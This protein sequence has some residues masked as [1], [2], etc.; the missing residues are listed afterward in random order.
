METD[1]ALL[2]QKIDLL[3]QIVEA[4]NRRLEMLETSGNR[5]AIGNDALLEKLDY[6]VHQADAER[7][8]REE[9]EELKRD[10][11]PI[12]NHMIKLSI[13]ELAE[14]GTEFQAED[15]V[16]VLK[17]LLRDTKMLGEGLQR[18]ESMM[19]LYDET[20]VLGKQ[21]FNQAVSTLDH[22]ERQGYFA[23]ARGG[24]RM[25]ERIVTE[26]SEEDVQALSDNIVLILNTIKDMTQPE[27]MNFVRNTLL[28]AEREVEQP[29]DISYPGLFR[30]MRD[31]E[32]R[33]GLALTMR[34]MHVIGAQA[35]N[36]PQAQATN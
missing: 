12:A 29:V 17:R 34:V 21:V 36:N 11:L 28:V 13:D 7:R 31:P 26:F 22:M 10:V 15:L 4:Q 19:E 5:D 23:F 1:L 6:L 18:L 14:I 33:R 16:F 2:H 30:Q 3:T 20:Q 27:I 9:M 35:S 32:V 24:W 25:I 8:S